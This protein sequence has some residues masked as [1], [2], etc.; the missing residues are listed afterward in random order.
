MEKEPFRGRYHLSPPKVSENP[1]NHNQIL[2]WGEAILLPKQST[3]EN[4]FILFY[5]SQEY[6]AI[7]PVCGLFY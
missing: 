3:A 2:T 7:V 4:L 5:I 6:P 1:R